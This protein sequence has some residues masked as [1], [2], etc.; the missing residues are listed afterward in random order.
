MDPELNCTFDSA[1]LSGQAT[2]KQF[3]AKLKVTHASP[4]CTVEVTVD[5]P[6]H[7]ALVKGVV[8]KTLSKKLDETLA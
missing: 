8:E 6:F 4:G 7:L 2:G 5:L 1:S 3:K